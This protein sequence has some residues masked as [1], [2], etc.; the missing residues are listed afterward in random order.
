MTG[1]LPL[2]AEEATRLATLLPLSVVEAIAGRLQ[3]GS[4]LAGEQWRSQIVQGVPNPLHRALARGF[5]DR[6]ARDAGH[7]GPQAVA[8]ALLAAA[9]ATDAAGR[10]HSVE[11]V[12][13][14]PD[15]ATSTVRRTEQA[16]LQVVGSANQRITLVSFAV[17]RIPHIRE[18]LVRAAA[19]EVKI[20]IVVETPD[21][22]ETE[23]EYNTLAA[24]GAEV[25][26][27]STVY[28]WPKAH[29]TSDE[30]GR[31]GLLHVKCVVGDGNQLFLSSANLTNYAFNLNMELGVLITGGK[32]PAQIE[33]LFEQLIRDRVLMKC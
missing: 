22:L 27:C 13:T 8:A 19:R 7:V 2:I 32:A 21:R 10:Q 33:A 9:V 15:A 6:W 25:T 17:H 29:R 12:W 28:Y 24:L 5:L 26:A 23:N 3:A 20:T 14:G 18:A 11:L 16:I 4:A 31:V 1:E 30:S